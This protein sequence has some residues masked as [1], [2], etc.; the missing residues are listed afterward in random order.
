MFDETSQT[1]LAILKFVSIGLSGA[2]G[3]VGLLTEFRD[4]HSHRITTWGRV[5]LVGIVVS[6]FVAAVSQAVEMENSSVEEAATRQKAAEELT[7]LARAA[8]PLDSLIFGAYETVNLNVPPFLSYRKRVLAIIQ[9]DLSQK[10]NHY[11]FPDGIYAS[12]FDRHANAVGFAIPLGSVAF[13]NAKNPGE[14]LA[15]YLLSRPSFYF[16]I[17]MAPI[18]NRASRPDLYVSTETVAPKTLALIY[19][20]Q[21]QSFAIECADIVVPPDKWENNGH[22]ISPV[23]FLNSRVEVGLIDPAFDVLDPRSVVVDTAT[24]YFRLVWFSVGLPKGRTIVLHASAMRL[25]GDLHSFEAVRYDRVLP[26]TLDELKQ[27]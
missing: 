23:D 7:Q 22:V 5:A 1:L 6:T 24:R 18:S 12:Y 19:D 25:R 2:F 27:R 4:K 3:V 26:A 16:D 15:Y 10:S 21:T 11:K 13:P 14:Q 9:R 20:A 8:D 17:S